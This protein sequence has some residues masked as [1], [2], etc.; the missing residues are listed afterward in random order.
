MQKYHWVYR[1]QQLTFLIIFV[2][3]PNQYVGQIIAYWSARLWRGTIFTVPVRM[4]KFSLYQLWPMAVETASF[5]F[6]VVLPIYLHGWRTGLLL[7]AVHFSFV[8]LLYFL[9]VA[10]NHDT[11]ATMHVSRESLGDWGEHQIRHSSNFSHSS[12]LL[13]A[14]FGGMNYQVCNVACVSVSGLRS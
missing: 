6:H 11:D 4:P 1:A 7:S 9:I 5:L 8:G 2:L 13:T 3:F 14:L 12:K 10:P